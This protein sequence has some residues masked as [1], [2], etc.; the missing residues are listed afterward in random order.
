METTST[1]SVPETAQELEEAFAH[2]MTQ[3]TEIREQMQA[4]DVSIRQSNTEY[5]VLKA[6]S[7]AL[8]KQTENILVGVRSRL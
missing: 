4:D 8:R 2:L 7:Q 1:A 6:E 3:I 5:A